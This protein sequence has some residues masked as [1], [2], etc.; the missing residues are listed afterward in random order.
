M[1]M[2]S[3]FSFSLNEVN[4]S[5]SLK[6]TWEY[7]LGKYSRDDFE[8]HSTLG[9]CMCVLR[10]KRKNMDIHGTCITSILSVPTGMLL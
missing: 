2:L 6:G 4:T 3:C 8:M 1:Q 5:K 7:E 10:E 9:V